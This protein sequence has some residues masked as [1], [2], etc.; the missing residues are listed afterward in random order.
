[1]FYENFYDCEMKAKLH[2]HFELMKYTPYFTLMYE[3]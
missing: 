3:V 1:M 2:I